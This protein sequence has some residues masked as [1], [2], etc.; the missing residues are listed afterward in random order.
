VQRYP[1]IICADMTSMLEKVAV[2]ERDIVAF[3]SQHGAS[4]RHY[5]IVV[6][7]FGKAL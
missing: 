6:Y 1:A 4:N 5:D 7:T 3:L 2:Y